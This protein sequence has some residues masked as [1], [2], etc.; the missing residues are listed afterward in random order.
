MRLP[1]V[2]ANVING[3]RHH[4][5]LPEHHFTLGFFYSYYQ[6][7]PIPDESQQHVVVVVVVVVKHQVRHRMVA[8]A[9]DRVRF[10][11][12]IGIALC[13]VSAYAYIPKKDRSH[14]KCA[15]L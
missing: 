14:A 13:I 10:I 1:A 4:Q 2:C 8:W 9:W 15:A 12:R 6:A 3:L 5:R 7:C 11:R